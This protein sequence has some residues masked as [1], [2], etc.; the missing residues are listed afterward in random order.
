MTPEDRGHSLERYQM[1][2]MV[3]PYDVVPGTPK[4]LKSAADT[5]IGNW[6]VPEFIGRWKLL[7]LGHIYAAAGGAQ[8]TAGTWRLQIAGADVVDS[9]SAAF[10]LASVASHL[11]S[12]TDETALNRTTAA[13]SL[14]APPVYPFAAAGQTV[15]A[16][17]ATQGVGAGS[18]TVYPYLVVQFKVN[19]AIAT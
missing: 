13:Q 16:L 19:P 17:V 18:Q 7:A 11:I 5:V 4:D 9:L 6:A 14:S 2:Q 12:D 15:K 10:V 8:T 1:P 3:L